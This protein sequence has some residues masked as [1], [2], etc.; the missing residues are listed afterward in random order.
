VT[1]CADAHVVQHLVTQHGS[2]AHWDE[3]TRV[4][5]ADAD[6][7]MALMR[8]SGGNLA[9]LALA[10]CLRDAAQAVF[11]LDDMG[12]DE[13]GD[14]N[15]LDCF[16]PGS[17]NVTVH[18]LEHYSKTKATSASWPKVMLDPDHTFG[19]HVH[20]ALDLPGYNFTRM[21]RA[22]VRV[23]HLQNMFRKRW[24][25]EAY[26]DRMVVPVDSY[27]WVLEPASRAKMVQP[28]WSL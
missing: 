5:H 7:W 16:T 24:A 22:C 28:E 13:C 15:E 4:F 2:L 11:H 9:D 21:D 8:R 12:A 27:Q 18:G 14:K 6:E 1:R 20:D 23:L 19:H 25:R 10:G 17:A 3:D 26:Y